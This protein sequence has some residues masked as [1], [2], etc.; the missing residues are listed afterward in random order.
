MVR[1]ESGDTGLLMEGASGASMYKVSGGE[2]KELS[3]KV[4][5]DGNAIGCLAI[6]INGEVASIFYTRVTLA[7][8][9]YYTVSGEAYPVGVKVRL[10]SV[11]DVN[12]FTISDL[13]AGALYATESGSDGTYSIENVEGTGETLIAWIQHSAQTYTDAATYNLTASAEATSTVTYV[14]SKAI[15]ESSYVECSTCGGSGTEAC[16]ACDGTGTYTSTTEE[17][18]DYEETCPDCEGSG[19]RSETCST[20]GGSGSETCPDCGGSGEVESGMDEDG[21]SVYET[22]PN[23]GGSGTVT[24]TYCGGSGNIDESCSYCGG[25]G[26]VTYTGS[27]T[28]EHEESC[29][30][31]DG[32][33]SRTCSSCG[34]NGYTDQI[35]LEDYEALAFVVTGKCNAGTEVIYVSTN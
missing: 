13:E 2:A 11:S 19:T 23:C 4:V 33:G 7:K 12:N 26:T 9:Y 3:P 34:G 20:C 16:S 32:Q 30:S 5:S 29:P 31:C 21:N 35:I 22:C 25:S 1:Y 8:G 10:S 17:P 24:C 18:Y 15:S 28:V 27:Q 14:T 6:R